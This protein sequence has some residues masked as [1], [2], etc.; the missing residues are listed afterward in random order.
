MCGEKG[1]LFFYPLDFMFV[2]P[3]EISAFHN[4]SN[5]FQ[6]RGAK[7]VGMSVASQEN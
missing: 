2:C 1:V 4:C 6:K 3:S 5:D 7:L